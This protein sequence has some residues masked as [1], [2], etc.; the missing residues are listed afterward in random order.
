MDFILIYV[1][2]NFRPLDFDCLGLDFNVVSFI[3]DIILEFLSKDISISIF[4]LNWFSWEHVFNTWEY[5]R[6][7][8]G[9]DVLTNVEEDISALFCNLTFWY[10][11]SQLIV[12]F[13]P[14]SIIWILAHA[15][16]MSKG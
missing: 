1:W 16:I 2:E 14:L 4:S 15:H 12:I 5:F 11:N 13:V 7:T 8:L 3:G 6:K 10:G 9:N